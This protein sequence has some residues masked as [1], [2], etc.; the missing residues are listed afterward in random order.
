MQRV[1]TWML[2]A[3][4]GWNGASVWAADKAPP[5]AS[6]KSAAAQDVK[7]VV[8]TPAEHVAYA[9]ALWKYLSRPASPYT[10]WKRAAAPIDIVAAPPATPGS[11]TYLN[12]VAAADPV[13]LAVGSLLVTEHFAADGKT[14]SAVTVAYRPAANYDPRN[15]DWYWAVL[16]PGGKH[17]ESSILPGPFSRRGFVTQEKDSRLWVF[18]VGSKELAEFAKSGPPAQH[19]IRPGAGPG[20]MT[21]RAPDYE[22]MDDYAISRPDFVARMVKGH[23]WVFRCGSK[24]AADFAKS[25]APAHNVTRVAAGPQG[26]TVRAPDAATIDEYLA[27]KSGFVT[28][29]KDGRLWVFRKGTKELEQFRKTGDLAQHVIRPGAGPAGMTLKSPDA[30]TIMEYL[31][32]RDGFS[33]VYKNDRLWVFRQGTEPLWKFRKD[34]DLAQ[35][36]I[37]PAVGPL[38]LTIKAP[39]AETAELYLKLAAQ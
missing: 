37:R 16:A 19:V 25:G 27:S 10:K 15:D 23:L 21:L 1:L 12:S 17:I 28:A 5:A 22:T 9:D 2:A 36:V 32:G 34:G 7:S 6:D 20:G 39:D 3:A 31:T 26:V 13:K 8:K 14:L 33:T 35:H 30:Q 24:E 38:G 4:C 11:V 18:R 29:M